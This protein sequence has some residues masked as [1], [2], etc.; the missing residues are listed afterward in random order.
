MKPK[1]TS[2]QTR[3]LA[4]DEEISAKYL[5]DFCADLS[6]NFKVRDYGKELTEEQKNVLASFPEDLKKLLKEIEKIEKEESED[7]EEEVGEEDPEINSLDSKKKASAKSAK[8]IQKKV[9]NQD[10]LKAIAGDLFIASCASTKPIKDSLEFHKKCQLGVEELNKFNKNGVNPL[11]AVLASGKD[12]KELDSFLKTQGVNINAKSEPSGNSAAHFAAMLG[13][14][15]EIM[16]TLIENGVN[17]NAKNNFGA[18]AF[19]IAALKGDE[20]MT[21]FLLKNGAKSGILI[22]IKTE[23]NK[24]QEPEGG[25]VGRNRKFV[26]M[27]SDESRSQ[28]SET[29]L[30]SHERPVQKEDQELRREIEKQEIARQ[31][32]ENSERRR[33]AEMAEIDIAFKLHQEHLIKSAKNLLEK[34]AGEEKLLQEA[35]ELK[36]KQEQ[37]LK[38][39]LQVKEKSLEKPS[40]PE[41]PLEKITGVKGVKISEVNI[42]KMLHESAEKGFLHVSKVLMEWGADP[43]HKES[44]K[45]VLEAAVSSGNESLALIVRSKTNEVDL[46]TPL[47][48]ASQDVKI[49]KNDAD[50]ISNREAEVGNL[51]KQS[52]KSLESSG[53]EKTVATEQ[54]TPSSKC[55]KVRDFSRVVG[56]KAHGILA[57]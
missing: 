47:A 12:S 43:H 49:P 55:E 51:F 32:V 25:L 14:K 22:E 50:K 7:V 20:K 34:K 11:V 36:V 30:P 26:E 4:S 39:N 45:T 8:K 9:E 1:N 15:S 33:N 57:Q 24:S 35:L 18:T 10:K 48:K 6:K 56:E 5:K 41:D 37:D 54:S 38:T 2:D 52:E 27:I 3:N 31:E 46:Q 17:L 40:Q 29:P 28:S 13:V 21:E 19:D 23:K 42:N 16:T 53:A 44:G